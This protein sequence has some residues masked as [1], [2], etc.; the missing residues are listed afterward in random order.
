MCPQVTCDA[1]EK[2]ESEEDWGKV[3]SWCEGKTQTRDGGEDNRGVGEDLGEDK[4]KRD[5]MNLG[6]IEVASSLMTE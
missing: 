6:I 5:G 4:P 2:G 3:G 1:K